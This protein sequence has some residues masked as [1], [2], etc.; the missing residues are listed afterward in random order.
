MQLQRSHVRDVCVL[1]VQS[2]L[3]SVEEGLRRLRRGLAALDPPGLEGVLAWRM[4]DNLDNKVP[5]AD[6]HLL[7]HKATTV[8]KMLLERA[9]A[10]DT[11]ESSP[12]ANP[13]IALAATLYANGISKSYGMRLGKENFV[14]DV[15]GVL[16]AFEQLYQA[17][18]YHKMKVVH[19]VSVQ[20]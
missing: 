11:S 12:T 15:R 16:D 17:G 2:K 5:E 4:Q 13:Y 7:Y 19:Q 8:C 1:C 10:E 18:A 14:A 9:G 6:A 20:L 3:L